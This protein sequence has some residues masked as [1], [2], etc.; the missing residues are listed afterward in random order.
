M[1]P[2]AD[3]L[4]GGVSIAIGTGALW[5]AVSANAYIFSMPKVRLL[6]ASLGR[7]GTRATLAAAALCLIALGIAIGCGW[8]WKWFSEPPEKIVVLA[9]AASPSIKLRH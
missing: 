8:K 3:W 7:T 4:V 5:G 6:E 9:C 1:S 2:Y